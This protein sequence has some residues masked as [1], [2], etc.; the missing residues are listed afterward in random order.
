[1]TRWTILL[2]DRRPLVG[3]CPACGAT[4]DDSGCRLLALADVLENDLGVERAGEVLCHRLAP[5]VEAP[6]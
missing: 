6:A 4:F 2:P 1:V 3:R 5:P